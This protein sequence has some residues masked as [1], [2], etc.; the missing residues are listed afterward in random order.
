VGAG[1]RL[2]QRTF[3]TLAAH[4]QVAQPYVAVHIVDAVAATSGRPNLLLTLTLGA[5]L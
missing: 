4:G 2:S 3:L 5:R 1:L